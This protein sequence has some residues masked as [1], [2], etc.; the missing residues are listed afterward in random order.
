MTSPLLERTGAVPA[1]PPDAGVAAHYG[2]PFRE[3]RAL[4]AGEASVD[5]SHRPVV[6][7]AGPDRLT[8]LHSL[9]SQHLEHLAPGVPTEA[10]VLSPKGHVEHALYLVDD[11]EATWAHVEPGTAE[12]LVGYLDRMRFWSKVEVE[13]LSS[14]YAVVLTPTGV[15]GAPS[16][17]TAHGV[18]SSC[19]APTWRRCSPA[20]S[21]GCGRSR[22]C[23]S[24]T[25]GRGSA[26]RPTTGPSR[27]RSAGSRPPCTWTRAATAGRRPSRGCTT[28]AGR[29]AGWCC[30]T[31]TAA[32]RS[33]PARGAGA[34]GRPRR[35]A[36]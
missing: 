16:R 18:E 31:S 4:V 24:P 32:T 10:L 7:I 21:P 23:A 25:A 5:L 29:R 34:A 26:W 17:V 11:G 15:P 20:R 9:T 14:A 19:R 33:C 1:D 30:C 35:S 8:W 3:Q 36:A 2:D 27:T 12:D 22:R 13:D 28:S 6:R